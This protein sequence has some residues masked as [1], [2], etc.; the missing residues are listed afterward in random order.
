MYALRISLLLVLPFVVTGSAIAQRVKKPCEEAQ[1]QLA[2]GNAP[3]LTLADINKNSD[4]YNN[5]FIRVIGIYRVAF[6]NSDLYDP[7]GGISSAWLAFDPFYAAVKRCSDRNLKVL[8]RKN[9]GT[10]GFVALGI[11][12]TKGR[13]GH[14]NGWS[15]EFNPICIEKVELLSDK[16]YVFE[17]QPAETK[18][19]ILE[20]YKSE[21]RKLY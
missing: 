18:S 7:S 1:I 21:V 3:D 2:G 8:N 19:K 11:I 20:W 9:G 16:G 4:C 12:K 10:F 6:E 15:Y 14:M 13:Y 5:G 17:S